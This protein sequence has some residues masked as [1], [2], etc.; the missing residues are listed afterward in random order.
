MWKSWRLGN[1]SSQMRPGSLAD[2]LQFPD[3]EN[4]HG[5]SRPGVIQ[6]DKNPEARVLP[7]LSGNEGPLSKNKHHDMDFQDEIVSIPTTD[8]GYSVI[9]SGGQEAANPGIIP[10][11]LSNEQWIVVAQ[12]KNS[13]LQDPEGLQS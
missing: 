13:N 3:S 5:D 11:P 10:R 4:E 7:L 1:D 12:P 9:E 2:N 6:S 8:R